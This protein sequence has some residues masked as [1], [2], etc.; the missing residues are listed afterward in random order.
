MA[1]GL[2]ALRLDSPRGV[3][4]RIRRQQHGGIR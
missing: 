3:G 1:A 4:K 2:G